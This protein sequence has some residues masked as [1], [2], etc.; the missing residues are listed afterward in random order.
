[1][2]GKS[3]HT[4]PTHHIRVVQE[5]ACTALNKLASEASFI[6]NPFIEQILNVYL[7][8]LDK[9]DGAIAIFIYGSLSSVASYS[10]NIKNS[11]NCFL[12]VENTP[13][14]CSAS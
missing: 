3:I 10:T 7:K 8:A 12:N 6:I 2:I 4:Y 9:E 11:Y 14:C 5:S 13:Y 1:M